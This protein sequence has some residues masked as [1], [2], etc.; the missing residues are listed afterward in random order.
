M[1]TNQKASVVIVDDEEM[2]ITSVRAYLQL[3]TEFEIHG[4]TEPEPAVK[5]MESHLV[6]IAVSDYLMPR[7]SGIQF[8]TRAKQ[9]QPEASRV[10][11]TG[12]ADKQSAIQ[13]INEVGLYQYV[14]KPW[15]NAQLLLIIQ[16]GIERSKLLRELREKVSEL[17]T[18]HSSLKNVQ[19][20]L[21]QAFL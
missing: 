3:E 16:N 1:G 10:L 7:M 13:A 15:E 18:A 19:K 21:L 8:L 9:I 5:H 17:D 14:E 12:H 11:L 2:V 20:R 4:F 6:D